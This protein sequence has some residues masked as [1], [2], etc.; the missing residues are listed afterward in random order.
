MISASDLLVGPRGRRFC[1]ELLRQVLDEES[2]A[3]EALHLAFFWADYHVDRD[4]GGSISLFGPGADRPEPPP[5]AAELARAV[6]AAVEASEPRTVGLAH[7]ARALAQTASSAMYWQEPDARD[8]LLAQPDLAPVVARLA[9]V[10]ASTPAVARLI[11]APRSQRQWSVEFDDEHGEHP[12]SAAAPDHAARALVTWRRALEAELAAVRAR[13]RRRPAA[14]NVGGSWWS[15]APSGLV[16]TTATLGVL[17]PI[18]LWAVEDDLGWERAT[19]A[20][21]D[22]SPDARV[23]VIDDAEGWGDLC[24]RWSVDVSGTT[25]RHDWY[26]TTGRDGAWVTPDWSGVAEEYDAV[27]LT[28]RAWLRAAGRAIAVGPDTASVIAGWTPDTTVWLRDPQPV[29][30]TTDAATWEFDGDDLGWS[31][32]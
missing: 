1:T 17:G 18:G 22:P 12:G 24:R 10:W 31:T 29:V 32:A 3:G 2:G 28:V 7:V 6:D 30:D 25:R 13:D 27:H 20:P 5:S 23:L 9:D 21:V 4:R 11:D 14:S 26:W 15:T 16:A 19:V 8:V